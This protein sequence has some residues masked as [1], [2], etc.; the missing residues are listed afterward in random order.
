ML[1]HAYLHCAVRVPDS[2]RPPMTYHVNVRYLAN[3]NSFGAGRLFPAY[4]AHTAWQT[5]LT[6][7]YMAVYER[8]RYASV[9]VG[10][11]GALQRE[12]VDRCKEA[13]G[14]FGQW[15]KDHEASLSS[16]IRDQ[17]RAVFDK[18][19]QI[20]RVAANLAYPCHQLSDHCV[21]YDGKGEPGQ[22]YYY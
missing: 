15:L 21:Y 22:N 11:D 2:I 8:V 20:R 18:Y 7:L 19:E 12:I 13:R 16:K 14:A 3:R 1:K 10:C 4:F 6:H 17:L 5:F 9:L